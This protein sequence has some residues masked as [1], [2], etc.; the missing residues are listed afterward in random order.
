[1]HAVIDFL[2]RHRVAYEV[3]EHRDTFAAT[4]EARAAGTDPDRMA[5]TVLLHDR[6]GFRVAVVPASEELDLHKARVPS[7][8]GTEWTP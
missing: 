4:S 6:D 8:G 7:A 5:K 3:I 1:M 2:E